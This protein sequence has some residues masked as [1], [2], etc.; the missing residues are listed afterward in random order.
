MEAEI[1]SKLK[2]MSDE[3]RTEYLLDIM[4]FIKEMYS[5]EGTNTAQNLENFK[6]IQIQKGQRRGDL[7]KKFT[8]KMNDGC[9]VQEYVDTTVCSRCSSSNLIMMAQTAEC[10]C[11]DCA[12]TVMY[13]DDSVI[14]YKDEQD[15]NKNIVYSYKRENHFNE[16]LYQFQAKESTNVPQNIIDDIK[17]DLRKQKVT[18]SSEITHAKIKSI[19]KK[20]GYNKYYEHTPHI[21]M[22][23]NGIKP[24]VMPQEA[25]DRLRLMF[26]KIQEPFDRHCPKERINFLSYS[27]VLY[28]FCELLEMDEYLQW[29]PL[30][31]SKEKLYKHDQIWKKITADLKWQFIPTI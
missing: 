30:L 3:A 12:N 15:L 31:K 1:N 25:E 27:Y 10:V 2:E 8:C 9:H 19:L 18:N 11:S 29:F 26:H 20:L 6:G 4:P 16:W 7:Y 21:T 5:D 13:M 24:P 14:G 22:M 17:A 23:V 28:K